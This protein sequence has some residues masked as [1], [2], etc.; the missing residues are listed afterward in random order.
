MGMVTDPRILRGRKGGIGRVK[1]GFL[2]H[3]EVKALV[4]TKVQKFQSNNIDSHCILLYDFHDVPQ[5]RPD[6]GIEV[7]A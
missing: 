2:F 7:R 1:S 5:F 6:L 3:A 4:S